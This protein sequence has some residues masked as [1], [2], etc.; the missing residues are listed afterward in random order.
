MAITKL[1]V[2]NFK[3]FDKLEVELHPFNIVVG[4]NASGK[5]NFLD[6]FKFL[7]DIAEDS[8]ESA[9]GIRGGGETLRNFNLNE[10]QTLRICVE[11]DDVL[12]RLVKSQVSRTF[13]KKTKRTTYE[14]SIRFDESD[15][16]YQVLTD[17]LTEFF[18]LIELDPVDN[19]G[20]PNANY[21]LPSISAP[22]DLV[23]G[24]YAERH[25]FG[26]GRARYHSEGILIACH[27]ELPEGVPFTADEFSSLH[28]RSL[29]VHG[30]QE[31]MLEQSHWR[32]LPLGTARSLANISAYDLDPRK[33]QQAV[34]I[35]GSRE[36]AP[37]AANL[38]VVLRQ[39]LRRPISKNRLIN[40]VSALLPFVHDLDVEEFGFGQLI[41]TLTERFSEK[42]HRLPA[43][44]ASD[45]TIACL[46]LVVALYFQESAVAVFEEPDRHVHPHLAGQ[47]MQMMNEVTDETQVIV[48]TH[49][50][51]LLRHANLE[52]IL[53][54]TRDPDGH[55]QITRPA[56]SEVVSHFLQNELGVEDL[57]A[58]N[59]LSL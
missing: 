13:G 21:W 14:L 31:V 44:F 52:D 7:R 38:A 37:D 27:V 57:F 25:N 19:Q 20:E 16:G 3:S 1:T 50:P 53:L 55:S 35:S 51:E 29:A 56:D 4:S 41:T 54:V 9:I 33:P 30:P 48:T 40:L 2:E 11:T 45:G 36:L 46:A 42:D 47:V 22:S 49:N 39:I 12:A 59:L 24:F 58:Q 34:P 28:G 10:D 15:L 23:P 5:S 32:A 26:T 18:T 43:A 17:S 8:L 6:V